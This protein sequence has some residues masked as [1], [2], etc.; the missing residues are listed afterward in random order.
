[1]WGTAPP[2]T[3]AAWRFPVIRGNH[4]SG[5]RLFTFTL[6]VWN[7]S[8]HTFECSHEC[9]KNVVTWLKPVPGPLFTELG[10]SLVFQ[11]VTVKSR[12]PYCVFS[13]RGTFNRRV[14]STRVGP[15]IEGRPLPSIIR[16][17]ASAGLSYSHT[18]YEYSRLDLTTSIF[19]ASINFDCN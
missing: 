4:W 6:N 9:S 14:N 19:Y 15:S 2:L 17:A 10:L 11:S 16:Q 5:Y 7:P 18:C 3:L 1:M 13:G 12:R 8:Q